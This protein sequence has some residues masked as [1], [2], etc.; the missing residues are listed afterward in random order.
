MTGSMWVAVVLT[1]LKFRF[2]WIAISNLLSKNRVF[3][4]RGRTNIPSARLSVPARSSATT[5]RR[6]DAVKVIPHRPT[7]T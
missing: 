4:V 3:Y 6:G 5:K 1:A 7:S 2:R